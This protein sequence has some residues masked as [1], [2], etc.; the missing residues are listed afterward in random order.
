MSSV[1]QKSLFV[2]REP[3]ETT[4]D[5]SW[6]DASFNEWMY[7]E[8]GSLYSI[9]NDS[10]RELPPMT[11]QFEPANDVEI[12]WIDDDEDVDNKDEQQ[13][14]VASAQE[15]AGIL[16]KELGYKHNT[17]RMLTLYGSLCCALLLV[18]VLAVS[19]TVP[20]SNVHASSNQAA[21]GIQ[22]GAVPSP[23]A[24]PSAAPTVKNWDAE[25]LKASKANVLAAVSTCGDQS[26]L[27]DPTSYQAAAADLLA[28]Q[29]ANRARAN[30][31]GDGVSFSSAY[32]DSALLERYA[33][34]TFFL[35]TGGDVGDSWTM[36][37]QWTTTWSTCQ[38]A[39]VE[40]VTGSDDLCVGALYLRK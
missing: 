16:N 22:D 11:S 37:S 24:S 17:R 39:G 1:E 34:I 8:E 23:L 32:T 40:C 4:F 12:R 2:E 14:A 6:N 30:D 3:S 15:N 21:G 36:D 5:A 35:A 28:E 19:L 7:G 31:A 27:Q 33:L 25:F 18:I 13:R 10:K 29:V 38:W 26:L 9:A 20:K